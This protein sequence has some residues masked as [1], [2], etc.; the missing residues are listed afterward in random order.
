MKNNR[1]LIRILAFLIAYPVVILAQEGVRLEY[2][3]SFPNDSGEMQ[4]ID[5]YGWYYFRG[6]S[7]QAA[8]GSKLVHRN[9]GSVASANVRAETPHGDNMT[10]GFLVIASNVSSQFVYTAI[11]V[12]EGNGI[13]GL[14]VDMNHSGNTTEDKWRFAIRIGRDWYVSADIIRARNE[15]TR[16][17]M[18]LRDDSEW[19]RLDFSPGNRLRIG[20][21]TVLFS[22]IRGALSGAGI[23]GEPESNSWKR[24][25]NFQIT[26]GHR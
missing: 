25:D 23:F 15:W 6:A 24:F 7:A 13:V 1:S 12:E 26:S 22:E 19:K 2:L 5:Q 17:V 18:F 3:Q 14:S 16:F 21:E 9:H 20:S 10:R 11:R 4:S 8:L